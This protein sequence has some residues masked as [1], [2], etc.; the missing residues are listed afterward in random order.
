MSRWLDMFRETQA[1]VDTPVTIAT[2]GDNSSRS[3]LTSPIVPTVTDIEAES[4]GGLARAT[5]PVPLH[6]VH[7]ADES[8]MRGLFRRGKN[9]SQGEWNS[10]Y[11]QPKGWFV[12][13]RGGGGSRGG[14]PGA[15]G[16]RPSRW[17][18]IASREPARRGQPSPS[19]GD[20]AD[21]TSAHHPMISV[22]YNQGTMVTHHPTHKWVSL[23][24]A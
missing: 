23:P 12:T 13:H 1:A 14:A 2:L 3:D 5:P 22:V 4:E 10:M 24:A 20:T 11:A 17:P 9:W 16:Q 7:M 15:G 19:P 18:R 21:T 8:G 6:E